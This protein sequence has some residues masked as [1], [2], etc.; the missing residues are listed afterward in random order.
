VRDR[1]GPE[2]GKRYEK[3]R[4]LVVDDNAINRLLMVTLL[5]QKG[6]K[7]AEAVDGADAVEKAR[8]EKYDL[9]L[10]DIRMPVMDGMRATE[11]IRREGAN[12]TTP[13]VALTAHALESEQAE[14]LAAGMD[15]CLVKP[16]AESDLDQLLE[17]TLEP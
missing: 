17:R 7:V 3:H 8:T 11:A 5:S 9:I 15:E 13:T 1:E 2:P 10:M 14:F 12:R 4:A 16:V 6:L